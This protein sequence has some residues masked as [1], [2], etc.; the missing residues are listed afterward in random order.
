M[1]GYVPSQD[2]SGALRRRSPPT[3]HSRRSRKALSS[4]DGGSIVVSSLGVVSHE[5]TSCSISVA[6]AHTG[7][8]DT[9]KALSPSTGEDMPGKVI[10]PFP[11]VG[12]TKAKAMD[13]GP[14]GLVRF[15]M[16]EILLS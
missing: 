3:N 9:F 13:R 11:V 16:A 8:V 15:R 4:A 12:T 6:V 2:P 1:D 10:T 7:A 5:I 14:R